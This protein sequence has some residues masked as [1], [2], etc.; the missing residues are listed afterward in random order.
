MYVF[1][2]LTETLYSLI[3]LVVILLSNMVDIV[4]ICRIN[5]VQAVFKAQA[6]NTFIHT[7]LVR[8]QS[9]TARDVENISGYSPRRKKEIL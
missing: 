7:P 9:L 2:A 4:K 3:L 8:T 1:F 5:R 6:H